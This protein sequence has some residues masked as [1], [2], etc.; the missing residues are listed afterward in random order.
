MSRPEM[1]YQELA[2]YFINVQTFSYL[3]LE[4]IFEIEDIS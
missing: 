3:M 4:Y 2:Q 1:K